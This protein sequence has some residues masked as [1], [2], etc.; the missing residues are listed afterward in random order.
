LPEEVGSPK[1]LT[2]HFK[3]LPQGS[4]RVSIVDDEHGSPLPAYK[5]LGAPQ[6]PTPAQIAQL[7]KA[8][9]LPDA[10]PRAINHET[11]TITLQPRA[12]ALV[13][14]TK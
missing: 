11:L 5:E 7:R 14:I 10:Q 9:A 3:G 13:E 8:A 12:L 1:D 2:L 4:A 6:S